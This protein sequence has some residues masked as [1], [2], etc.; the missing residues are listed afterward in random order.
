[1]PYIKTNRL[2][3]ITFTVQMIEAALNGREELEKIV[4]YNVADE[5]PLDVY[6]QFFPYKIDRF[7]NF[8]EEN[9]WEGIIIHNE[10][11]CIIGDMGFKG[12]P[13][14]KGEMDIGYSIVPS[15]QG[16]GY[17]T[18]MAIAMVEWGLRQ[19]DVKKITASCSDHNTASIKVLTKAGLKQIGKQDDELFWSVEK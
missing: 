4:D 6:K 12:G 9:E 3:I 18:E 13:D 7:S 14:E 5:Y 10:D 17:A 11:N 2:T 19:P 15:Y 1:M 8:P 16:K